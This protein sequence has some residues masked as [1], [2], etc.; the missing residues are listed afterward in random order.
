MANDYLMISD[1]TSSSSCV[2]ELIGEQFLCCSVLQI[3]HLS[4]LGEWERL[5]KQGIT[6]V[7][8]LYGVLQ[9]SQSPYERRS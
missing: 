8:L 1:S 2:Q 4:C 5:E 3:G 9:H 6:A 7:T